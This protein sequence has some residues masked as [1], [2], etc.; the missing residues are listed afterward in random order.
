MNTFEK[1]SLE[2]FHKQT[3]LTMASLRLSFQS[4]AHPDFQKLLEM[5][6]QFPQVQPLIPISPYQA[7]AYLKDQA[8]EARQEILSKMIPGTRIAIA[9]DCWLSPNNHA[10]IATTG[11]VQFLVA[12]YFAY[13]N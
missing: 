10:F 4:I 5:A 11:L 1:G 6:H 2:A 9:L 13:C 12:Y 8:I 3:V 7:K